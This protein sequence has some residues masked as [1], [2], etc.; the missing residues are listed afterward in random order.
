M[1]RPDCLVKLL[2]AGDEVSQSPMMMLET[3]A[4]CPAATSPA[5]QDY[6]SIT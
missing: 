5:V 6:S 1:K 2:V 3:S 4:N